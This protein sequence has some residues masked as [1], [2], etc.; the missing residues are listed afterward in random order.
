[1]QDDTEGIDVAAGV[2]RQP[3]ALLGAAVLSGAEKRSGFRRRLIF[4]F[5]QPGDP[6]VDHLRP[7]IGID[8]NVARF[9][10][11]VDDASDMPVGDRPTDLGEQRQSLSCGPL[12]ATDT[13][14]ASP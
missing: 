8:Q 12:P 3:L 10:V 14:A 5:F 4:G 1:M 13:R 11:A 2:H 6:E 9:E 7:T